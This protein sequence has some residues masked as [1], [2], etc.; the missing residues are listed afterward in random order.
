[1]RQVEDFCDIESGELQ[2]EAWGEFANVALSM[3]GMYASHLYHRAEL[4]KSQELHNEQIKISRQQH[5]TEIK[6]SHGMHT[7][8]VDLDRVRNALVVVK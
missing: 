5:V 7:E 4:K 3:V 2:S 6:Q 1:M 8:S